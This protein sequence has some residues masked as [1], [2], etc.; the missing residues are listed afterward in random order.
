VLSALP[1]TKRL[2]TSAISRPAEWWQEGRLAFEQTAGYALTDLQGRR[3]G[4]HSLPIYRYPLIGSEHKARSAFSALPQRIALT[5]PPSHGKPRPQRL[6]RA[7][8]SRT[9]STALPTPQNHI[10]PRLPQA[11][12]AMRERQFRQRPQVFSSTTACQGHG[13]DQRAR[14]QFLARSPRQERFL[15][16]DKQPSTQK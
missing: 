8:E 5:P 1:D 4:T 6:R 12:K 16:A 9:T 13:S 7:H 2:A 11:P 15:A 14:R 10:A 3:S